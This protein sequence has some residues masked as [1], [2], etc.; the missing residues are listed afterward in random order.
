MRLDVLDSADKWIAS[1]MLEV[2][3]ITKQA[4]VHYLDWPSAYDEW[5]NLDS[6]RFAPLHTHTKPK[7]R[8][9]HDVNVPEARRTQ[10]QSQ[11][12]TRELEIAVMA[13]DGNC[14]FRSISHQVYGTADYHN[15]VRQSCADYIVCAF[16]EMTGSRCMA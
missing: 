2:N 1:H 9:T 11:L 4:L 12:T 7:Q 8:V 16:T 15:V 10:Y 3:G 5:I 13:A 14:L 6:Y